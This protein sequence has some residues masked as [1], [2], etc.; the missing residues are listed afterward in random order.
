MLVLV[1]TLI[2]LGSFFSIHPTSAW[3]NSKSWASQ[4]VG[5]NPVSGNIEQPL[6]N[7]YLGQGSTV[8]S[9]ILQ[10][11]PNAQAGFLEAWKTAMVNMY[12]NEF[13]SFVIPSDQGYTTPGSQLYGKDLFFE[14]T[15]KAILNDTGNHTTTRN[16]VVNVIYSLYT[17][18]QDPSSTTTSTSAVVGPKASP[19]DYAP[20][21]VVGGLAGVA[22]IG[23]VGYFAYNNRTTNLSTDKII[24]KTRKKETQSIQSLKESL[25]SNAEK[26]SSSVSKK[27]S[28]A[29]RRR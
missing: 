2:T 15:L 24:T 4:A 18:C 16:S 12:L 8:P 26:K 29:R 27:S 3:N 22:I 9:T 6:N 21:I 20:Y 5:C 10:Q 14:I 23:A 7:V 17:D 19:P 28:S 11:Y 13:K 1:L 25:S